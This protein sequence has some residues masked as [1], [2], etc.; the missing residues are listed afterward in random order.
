MKFLNPLADMMLFL[1]VLLLCVACGGGDSTGTSGSNAQSVQ[2]GEA[3]PGPP[4]GLAESGELPDSFEEFLVSEMRFL[5]VAEDDD[6]LESLGLMLKMFPFED[7][8]PEASAWQEEQTR[9]DEVFQDWIR[10]NLPEALKALEGEPSTAVPFYNEIIRI[11]DEGMERRFLH[12]TDPEYRETVL[13][14]VGHASREPIGGLSDLNWDGYHWLPYALHALDMSELDEGQRDML[15]VHI[16]GIFSYMHL[17][18][19]ERD[20]FLLAA[21]QLRRDFADFVQDQ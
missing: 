2:N 21:S 16:A 8:P 18:S 7:S 6:Q 17:K 3:S 15:R 5:G 1:T 9:M 10:D 12:K 11:T 14:V 19:D 13:R 4:G 20:F